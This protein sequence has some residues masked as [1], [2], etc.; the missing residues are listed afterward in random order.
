M[1]CPSGASNIYGPT[2]ADPE[3]GIVFVS[4]QRSCRAENMVPGAQMDEP[5]DPK[6]T[7]KTLSQWVVANRGDLRGPQG[8]PIW[9]P[10]YSRIVAIDMKTGEFLWEIPNGDTPAHIRNHPALK[11]VTIP[12]T[13]E[14]SHAVM[15]ATKTLLIS[16]PGGTP[17][18]YAI[19]KQT[20]RRLGSVKLPAPSQYGLMGYMH[21]GRQYVRGTGGRGRASR[22]AGRFAPAGAQGA[23]GPLRRAAM[24]NRDSVRV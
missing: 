16:S 22:I 17:V 8:L 21:Q 7:G 20:G 3:N 9:K 24:N 13:G 6:T 2:V 1:S 4:T 12:T 23:R 15:L 5:E 10:P 18:L 19:D 14:Q 11:G